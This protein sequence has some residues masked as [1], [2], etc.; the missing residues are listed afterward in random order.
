MK[1][2]K[3]TVYRCVDAEA[4]GKIKRTALIFTGLISL[5]AFV[6]TV[7]NIV[8]LY[9]EF[10]FYSA[11]AVF[12]FSSG[13]FLLIWKERFVFGGSLFLFG[14]L[15]VLMAEPHLLLDQTHSLAVYLIGNMAGYVLL[16]SFAGFL[17]GRLQLIIATV[18]VTADLVVVTFLSEDPDM[19]AALLYLV[20]GVV[21]S[22][23]FF[24]FM[25][26]LF[27]DFFGRIRKEKDLKEKNL[28]EKELLLKELHHRVKNNMQI[29]SSF[30]SLQSE[31]AE[32]GVSKGLFR[33]SR[34]R[35]MVMA[36][37]HDNIFG[38][39]D[40]EHVDLAGC[41]RDITESLSGEYDTGPGPRVRVDYRL[42]SL[43]VG[44]QKAVLC[45]LILNELLLNIYQH[46]FPHRQK[47][48]KIV[49]ILRKEGGEASL[50]VQDNGV[51]IPETAGEKGGGIGLMVIDALTNQLQ[52]KSSIA[53]ENGSSFR[54]FFPL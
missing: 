15:A 26:R 35:I 23:V 25:S 50:E 16:L 20:L 5:L 10:D 14:A 46:A 2:L 51:G 22:G 45:C 9:F 33:D 17:L 7:W 27:V 43:D 36:I 28:K 31:K 3:D 37:V 13:G 29:V 6:L 8:I 4:Q 21:M 19:H 38:S 12:V 34:N 18:L 54:I 42:E 40:L 39:E 41:I 32:D 1:I 11:L 48:K 49:I 44:L 53:G 52:G 47:E 24:F 30:L